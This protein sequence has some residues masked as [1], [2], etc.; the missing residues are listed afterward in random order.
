MQKFNASWEK[1][2]GTDRQRPFILADS[3]WAGSTSYAVPLVTN[4]ERNWESLRGMISS[5][6]SLSMVGARNVMVDGCG[7][8]GPLDQELCARWMQAAA[9]M[10]MVRLYY[11][12]AY[13]D[14][15]GDLK[16]SDPGNI[17]DFTNE[18]YRNM[19]I[20][21][22]KQRQ[23]FTLYLYSEMFDVTDASSPMVAPLFFYAP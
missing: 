22:V 4:L 9:F 11:Q 12:V 20:N 15:K 14:K 6:F 13:I 8:I 16:R 21:A 19:A 7:S 2:S 17:Y 23:R 18:R 3:T 1:Y 10:P 5:V